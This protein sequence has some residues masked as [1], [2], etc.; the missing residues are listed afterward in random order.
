MGGSPDCMK[1][2]LAWAPVMN[3]SLGPTE[4]NCSM[5]LILSW[6][7]IIHGSMMK[8]CPLSDSFYIILVYMLLI[9][10]MY[11]YLVT[12]HQ[13]NSLSHCLLQQHITVTA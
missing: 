9:S 13:I 12:I 8:L 11:H 5:C 3:P 4:V 10:A 6:G 7:R 1:N 2:P